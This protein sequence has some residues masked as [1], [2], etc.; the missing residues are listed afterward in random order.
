MDNPIR[1]HWLDP[2]NPDQPFPPV[3]QAMVEPNGLLAIGGDLSPSRM[4]RAYAQGIFPWYNPDEPILWWCPD[5]RTVI[6]PGQMHVSRSLR[7]AIRRADYAVTMNQDFDQV[8]RRCA[9]PRSGQ[10]GT[11]LGPE[12]RHAYRELHDAGFCQSI[13]IWRFGR[14]IGGLYGISLGRSFFGES[15]FSHATNGSKLAL[16]YLSEQ[17]AAWQ[18]DLIDCQIS[19]QHLLSLGA[20]ELP[21][22][23]FQQIL[24]T[25]VRRPGRAG[26]WQIEIDCPTAPEHRPDY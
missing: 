7:R 10:K 17:L 22:P 11:W 21:R 25:S 19:S 15:M 20:E 4:I 9:A 6:R 8:I 16:Y 23:Q 3:E 18:F 13:E 12:M 26:P 5:P 2:R 1:L 24:N 14:L